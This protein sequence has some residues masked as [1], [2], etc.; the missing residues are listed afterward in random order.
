VLDEIAAHLSHRSAGEHGVI[1]TPD[2]KPVDAAR[3]GYYFRQPCGVPELGHGSLPG[4]LR[5]S[6][7]FAGEAAEDGPTLDPL[8][9]EVSDGEAGPGRAE[10]AAAVGAPV[11]VP[12]VLS[13]DGPQVAFAEDQHPVGDLRPGGEHEPF[14]VAFARGASTGVLMMRTRWR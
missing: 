5:G 6:L 7:V 4:L 10:L 8:P 11:V 13:Q 14:G 1:V 12:G 3:W 9:G 2:G